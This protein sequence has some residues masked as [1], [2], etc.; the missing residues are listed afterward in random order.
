[1]TA[2]SAPVPKVPR[3]P[4]AAPPDEDCSNTQVRGGTFHNKLSQMK[5]REWTVQPQTPAMKCH[6]GEEKEGEKLAEASVLGRYGRVGGR[7]TG[8]Q[9]PIQGLVHTHLPNEADDNIHYRHPTP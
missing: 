9:G 7:S 3:L 5:E 4:K 8:V 6:A 1:M 2:V